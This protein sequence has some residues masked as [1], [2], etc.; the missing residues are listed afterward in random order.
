VR[1]LVAASVLLLGGCN[2]LTGV[3]DLEEVPCTTDCVD[4]AAIDSTIE[5]TTPETSIEDSG[6]PDTAKPDTGPADTFVPCKTNGDCADKDD[7]TTDL[8]DLDGGTCSHPKIDGDMDGESPTSA[9]AC[10]MDCDDNNKNVFSKQTAFFGTPYLGSA[11]TSSFDYD[12]NGVEEREK[13]TIFKCVLTAG[14]CVLTEGWNSSV[15]AC[16][17]NGTYVTACVLSPLTGTCIPNTSTKS[18]QACR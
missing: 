11:G 2:A 8:C 16:G 5:D 7:C 18:R 10:G 9:G 12:C 4:D 1:F 14:K 3:G 17:N 15:P 13:T 6:A